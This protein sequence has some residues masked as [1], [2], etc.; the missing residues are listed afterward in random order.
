MG[1]WACAA[2]ELQY[3]DV[4][5]ALD[6]DK[7]A[8]GCYC[9]NH[10]GQVVLNPGHLSPP[11]SDQKL[12]VC[13]DFEV[14]Y[15]FV[16][17]RWRDSCSLHLSWSNRSSV[18]FS[19]DYL[20]AGG[21]MTWTIRDAYG[22]VRWASKFEA[23][24]ALGFS[25][26]T[27]LPKDED[28][29][30][31][32][33]GQSVS[34]FQA[35]L[36]M[37]QIQE[38]CRQQGHATPNQGF[39][40]TMTLLRNKQGF[41]DTF[42][43]RDHG[44]AH[45]SLATRLSTPTQLEIQCPHCHLMT[46]QP[47][48]LAC[49]KCCMVACHRCLTDDC[50]DSHF[51]VVQETTAQQE[52]DELNRLYQP[53]LA[54]RRLFSV[55]RVETGFQEN[56]DCD[57]AQ[58]V[59]QAYLY[60][61]LPQGSTFFK[62]QIM[63]RDD[64]APQHGDILHAIRNN[65]QDDACPLCLTHAMNR[66]LRLCLMCNRIGCALCIVDKCSRCTG[67]ALS[68][69][70]CHERAA[71][72]HIR[73]LHEHASLQL[74]HDTQ[75]CLP[76][77]DW[78]LSC[79]I[80]AEWELLTVLAYPSG[81]ATV[82]RSLF[83]NTTHIVD[84]VKR[85][86]YDLPS[87]VQIFWGDSVK[88]HLHKAVEG[89][90]LVVPTDQ[91]G[92]GRIP[93][94]C[95]THKGEHVKMCPPTQ[96]LNA[97]IRSMLNLD[98]RQAGY[99]VLYRQ[100]VLQGTST[101]TLATG[102]VLTKVPPWSQQ[103]RSLDCPEEG[104]HLLDSV[105]TE[106]P[107]PLQTAGLGGSFPGTITNWCGVVMLSGTFQP[108]PVP[109]PG[110]TWGQWTAHLPLPDHE[111]I[112]ATSNGRH[113]PPDQ[114]LDGRPILLRLHARGRGGGK[115]SGKHDA[116]AKKLATHLQSKGVPS[117]EA[118]SRA[119]AVINV[120]GTSAVQEAYDSMDPWRALKSAAGNRIRLVKPEELKA[121]KTRTVSAASND[122]GPDPWAASDPWSQGR[123]P[124]ETSPTTSDAPI[125]LLPGFFLDQEAQP[126]PI[127]Q[128][129][130]AEGKGVALLNVEETQIHA[131]ANYLLSEEELAAI[132]V[133]PT[134]PSTGQMPCRPIS[135]AA[136]HGEQKVLLRGYIVDVG[137]KAAKLKVRREYQATWE[138]VAKNPL[139]YVWSVIDGLQQA[140]ATTWSRK[141]FNGRKEATADTATTWHCFAKIPGN[142]IDQYL[143]QSGKGGVFVIPKANGDASLAGHFRVI[144]LDHTDL[145]RAVTLQR[146]YPDI[147]GLVRGRD[148]LGVR[149][150]A[151]DYSGTRKKIEPSWSPQ[152]LLTDLVVEVRWSIAPLP[153]HTDKAAVQRIIK[154]LNWK[155]VP[156]KQL[157]STTWVVGSSATD[158]APTDVFDFDN[159]PALITR[160][161]VRQANLPA[162]M[163]LAAPPASKKSLVSRFT[164]GRWQAPAIQSQD[165]SMEPTPGPPVTARALM[166]ELRDEVN[167]RLG[168]F[169]AQ[170]QQTVNQVNVKV[171][172]ARDT[173]ASCTMETE[174]M[175]QRQDAR[176][177]QLET[178]VQQ[179][180]NH[181]VTKTDLQDALKAAMELQSREIRTFLAKRSPDV[182][183]TNDPKVR[184]I[185][186]YG[187]H[188]G[189]KD[190]LTKNDILLGKILHRAQAFDLPVIVTGDLNCDINQL[191]AWHAAVARGYVDV[192]A[193][194][195]ALSSSEP[196]P[197]YKGQSRLD[198]VLC[199]RAAAVA[200]QALSADPQGFTD[201]AALSASFDWGLFQ[202]VVPR[203][204]FPR[205]LDD[206]PKT[207][208]QVASLVA[209][210][211]LHEQFCAAIQSNDAEAALG[212]FARIYEDKVSRAYRQ[213]VST[214]IPPKF[215]GRTRC[216]IQKLKGGPVVA[217]PETQS[218]A[219]GFRVVCFDKARRWL[220]ELQSLQNKDA[221]IAKQHVL[222]KKIVRCEGF[223]PS[224]PEWPLSHD[225][226]LSV[227]FELPSGE[228]IQHVAQ[229]IQ[230]ECKLLQMLQDREKN[231]MILRNMKLDWSKG[232]R[233]HSQ[234]IKPVPLGTMDS[235]MVKKERSFH[236]LRCCKGKEAQISFHD[237]L[238]TPPGTQLTFHGKE[239]VI[240]AAVVKASHKVEWNMPANG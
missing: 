193:R 238:P 71:D 142:G 143:T 128:H 125:S 107:Q 67:G 214:T 75:P 231:A 189:I 186:V 49:R 22:D 146:T 160:Q 34:P 63:V 69:R 12:I 234:S 60:C 81:R 132:V 149:L 102:E 55:I 225:V 161:N 29:G 216:K 211:Q 112:W 183:P 212:L 47:L 3:W 175:L 162:Q 208:G 158:L 42:F 89:Y 222:W 8:I 94:V 116:L 182:T 103:S 16:L 78:T 229:A 40:E 52:L 227:P 165:S 187:Y 9:L 240:Q 85:M 108:L 221:D 237:G 21:L 109:L 188:S 220:Q 199:N 181:I 7:S 68:C 46:N 226:V 45:E 11:L 74:E 59:G 137:Q 170:I 100:Q 91:L 200:F 178:S 5:V 141:Y 191:E 4:Q 101:L 163:V 95:R 147:L 233:L 38:V 179:L 223:S 197:T 172:E 32:A 133:S 151:S 121:A 138:T 84:T 129:L 190:S 62:D 44:L 177:T 180:S 206:Q 79:D 185:A 230:Y 70:T 99:K 154:E 124:K 113:L 209:Q 66:Q 224:F 144:W 152:G 50:M 96:P 153:P 92:Q 239:G 156:L 80:E 105:F 184:V 110:Q 93:V 64:Y 90:I 168:D 196:E 6:H 77:W 39:T 86:G 15:W 83:H 115:Q 117:E 27:I 219:E 130:V 150:R 215:L 120:V 20:S 140:T 198:Y 217:L 136:M 72:S 73:A 97:W 114:P 87:E 236:L 106:I 166:A 65:R 2:E 135:F 88:P 235:L 192:A 10:P 203:W 43:I 57:L 195:A 145:D 24:R 25:V 36:I 33:V 122:R 123:N 204:S 17:C 202:P 228:W 30:F 171:Q 119:E 131:S 61:D 76:E 26:T 18:S 207:L 28:E 111:H 56:L 35:A 164:A 82:K 1:G 213:V 54:G 37:C 19:R 23:A 173:A 169:Q 157:S 205:A 14:V 31:V 218:L 194:Q 210:P 126:L 58:N 139:R 201:H 48:L 148:T 127:L 155:A 118:T 98:E 232:G 174:A 134:P 41:M 104:M 51:T 167:Q 176:V 53:P 13:T 159:Q